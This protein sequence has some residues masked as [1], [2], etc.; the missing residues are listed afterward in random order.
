MVREYGEFHRIPSVEYQ[1]IGGNGEFD[2][3]LVRIW[4]PSLVTT[5]KAHRDAAVT[6]DD[7]PR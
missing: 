4:P 6:T 1:S 5:S 7:G 2:P 3:F